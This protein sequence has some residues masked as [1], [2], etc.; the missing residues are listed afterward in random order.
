M[1]IAQDREQPSFEVG[2]WLIARPLVPSLQDGFL[3]QVFSPIP[4]AGPGQRK[5]PQVR[6]SLHQFSHEGG[7]RSLV[8]GLDG[9]LQAAHK[10]SQVRRKAVR[11]QLVVKVTK[12]LPKMI[13]NR[14]FERSASIVDQ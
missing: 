4:I 3:H 14:L 11:N 10:T 8:A 13:N 5:G 9:P 7:V 1:L 2:S 12:L 6:R